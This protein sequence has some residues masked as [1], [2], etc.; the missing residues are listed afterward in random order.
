MKIAIVVGT[1]PEIIKMSPIIR[2][3]KNTNLN[4]ILIHTGQHY[5]YALD[6]I[7]FEELELPLPH[8]NLEIGSGSHAE[9]TGKCLINIEKVLVKEQPDVV[10]VEGDTNSVLAGGLAASKLHIKVG[11]V[12]AGLRSHDRSMPEE[13]NRIL[14]DHLSDFLFTPTHL[15]QSNL[16]EEGINE[17]KIFI[18]GNSI[19][20]AVHQNLEI[21]KKCP[22]ILEKL[23]IEPNRYFLLT[24]HRQENV[25]D[26][27]RLEGILN[28]LE[29]IYERWNLPIIYPIHPRTKKRLEEFG[30]QLPKGISVT[31]PLGFLEFLYLEANSLLI[32]T[33]SGGIQEEACILKVP[34]VTLRDNTERPE[35]LTVG[36]NILV[37]TNPSHILEGVTEMID[38]SRNWDNPLGDGKTGRRILNI[39]K[40]FLSL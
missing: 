18:T 7:F 23:N 36:A 40:E 24:S 31:E 28:G 8:Y 32:L 33:D 29:F 10:L 22:Q 14:V 30:L 37:G 6:K 1:R 26:K 34:C 5:S 15:A 19:V 16:L 3:C 38:K 20:D 27:T 39:L 4:Y 2:E 21:A 17:K 12:E 9:I 35:T 11:H 25:D 13:I